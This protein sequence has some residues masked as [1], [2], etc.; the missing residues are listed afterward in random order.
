MKVIGA[1]IQITGIH[2]FIDH[3]YL[4]ENPNDFARIFMQ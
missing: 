2:P 1:E 3:V 4:E